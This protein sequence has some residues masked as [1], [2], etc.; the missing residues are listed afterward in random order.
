MAT[1]SNP[2]PTPFETT[3]TPVLHPCFT[4]RPL[5]VTDHR[6]S[7]RR[8]RRTGIPRCW[9]AL[10]GGKW[11]KF[12]DLQSCLLW[13]LQVYFWHCVE[14]EQLF[15]SKLDLF[16][17]EVSDKTLQTSR[18]AHPIQIPTGSQGLT[19]KPAEP[20]YPTNIEV[21]TVSGEES[22]YI[23]TNSIG[24]EGQVKPASPFFG[25]PIHLWP[26]WLRM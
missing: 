7:D 2:T 3:A 11:W 9:N 6:N 4:K 13:I 26:R 14:E 8:A 10:H 12:L 21:H 17:V 25:S 20:L 19:S 18:H 1:F 15:S 16:K 5:P 24:G 23:S 22:R